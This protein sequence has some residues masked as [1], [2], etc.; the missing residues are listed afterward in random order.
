MVG[1]TEII[2]I[3]VVYIMSFLMVFLATWVDVNYYLDPKKRHRMV[4]NSN[5]S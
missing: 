5:Q 1:S 4:D 2:V 3:A